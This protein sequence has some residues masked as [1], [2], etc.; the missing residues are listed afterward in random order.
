MMEK[1]DA[2][3]AKHGGESPLLSALERH[4]MPTVLI[5]CAPAFVY[6]GWFALSKV[7]DDPVHWGQ[8]GDFVGGIVGT[9]VGLVTLAFLIATVRMQR[10]MV[11]LASQQLTTSQKELRDTTTALKQQ[12]FEA[13][14]FKMIDQ[15]RLAALSG[16]TVGA[17]GESIPPAGP[18]SRACLTA[19]E[20]SLPLGPTASADQINRAMTQVAECLKGNPSW[21]EPFF[22]L[23]YHTLKL[24]HYSGLPE[25]DRVRY[26]S[27]FRSQFTN[28]ELI[29]LYINLQTDA[30]AGLRP[31]ID[32]YGMLKHMPR[33]PGITRSTLV[34]RGPL[35]MSAFQSH[36]DRIAFGVQPDKSIRLPADAE[37]STP[38]Q[39]S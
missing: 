17:Q 8:F 10:R 34:T 33:L 11:L 14:F 37:T 1:V 31:Y 32:F 12:V 5:V 21:P 29:C 19:L 16:S 35:S 27:L 28:A 26:A 24:V 22:R 9:A 4:W 20:R 18:V 38:A 6:V 3:P 13:L 23:I 25:L 15:V 36:E 7:S 30:A 39:A 2:Q